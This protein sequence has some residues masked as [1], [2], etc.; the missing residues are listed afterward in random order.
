M[1]FWLT[2]YGTTGSLIGTDHV[3]A[4]CAR[5]EAAMETWLMLSATTY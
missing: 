5:P 2:A 1:G 4:A 3:F